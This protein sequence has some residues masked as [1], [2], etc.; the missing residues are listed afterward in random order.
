M[1]HM[2]NFYFNSYKKRVTTFKTSKNGILMQKCHVGCFRNM[3]FLTFLLLI[4]VM[5][6]FQHIEMIY[7]H[8]K[9]IVLILNI[10][11]TIFFN[12]KCQKRKFRDFQLNQ[13]ISSTI[14]SK[15]ISR[16]TI[17]GSGARPTNNDSKLKYA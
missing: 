1:S 12:K 3:H 9:V 13:H 16:H 2:F 7:S 10:L 4:L 17:L 8:F 11:F 15:K 5:R 14:M 6:Y